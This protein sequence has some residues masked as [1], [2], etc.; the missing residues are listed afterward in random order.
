M[1]FRHHQAIITKY[2][3]ATDY[4]PARIIATAQGGRVV[5]CYEFDGDLNEHEKAAMKLVDK[6]KWSEHGWVGTFLPGGKGAIVW[7]MT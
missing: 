6:M 1:L 7:V 4:K 5:H 2:V 3:S